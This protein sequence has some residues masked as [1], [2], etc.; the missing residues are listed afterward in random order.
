MNTVIGV[1][2]NCSLSTAGGALACR[3]VS[4]G[5]CPT[6]SDTL[7]V[8]APGPVSHWNDWACSHAFHGEGV[9]ECVGRLVAGGYA[10]L[11]CGVC[12]QAVGLGTVLHTTAGVGLSEVSVWTGANTGPAY[13]VGISVGCSGTRGLADSIAVRGVGIQGG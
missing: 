13:V 9:G 4:E 1:S 8:T 3:V 10:G 5:A 2:V 6:V 7:V 12:K 11:C